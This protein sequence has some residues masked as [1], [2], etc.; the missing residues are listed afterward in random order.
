MTVLLTPWA[1]HLD[2]EGDVFAPHPDNDTYMFPDGEVY[3]QYAAGVEAVTLVHAGAPD[4]DAGLQFLRAALHRFKERDVAVR[5]VFTYMPYSRQDAR[6]YDGTANQARQIIDELATWYG[7]EEIYAV[8]PHFG[9][10]DW[11]E[12]YPFQ[13][14]HAFEVLM[15]QVTMEDPVVVG[16]DG[17]A[18]QRFGIPGYAKERQ[19]AE[20]VSLRGD[21]PAAGRNVLVFDDIIA[22]GSS[23]EA[24]YTR[25]KE[26]GAERVE[27]A[28]VHGVMA[29][30]IRGVRETFDALHLTNAVPNNHANVRVEPVLRDVL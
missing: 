21:V 3:V 20:H 8:S 6:F 28:A 5:V 29:E 23:M 30:G 17:G 9:H 1:Q 2:L 18:V 4:A 14:L 24:A 19:D 13:E 16:P 27:A 7:V 22:T 10:R 11:V 15:D 12:G 25:L 26:E